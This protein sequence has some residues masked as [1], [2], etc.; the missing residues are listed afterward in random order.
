[1]GAA[2]RKNRGSQHTS[3][4]HQVTPS[5][6]ADTVKK[7]V[8]KPLTSTSRAL[9]MCGWFSIHWASLRGRTIT[10]AHYPAGSPHDVVGPREICSNCTNAVTVGP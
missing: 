5:H 9:L 6:S 4:R 3:M 8:T 10:P 2:R 1:M 7:I